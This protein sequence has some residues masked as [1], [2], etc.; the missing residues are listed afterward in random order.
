MKNNVLV[1]MSGGVDSAVCA[2]LLQS[3][4]MTVEGITMKLWSDTER[5]SD[6]EN[7]I[8]DQNCIDARSVADCLGIPHRFVTLG[9]TFRRTVIDPF[10][11]SYARG[12]TPNPCVECNRCVKFGY[13]MQLAHEQG[14]DYL[15]T[16]HY[17][18]IE[19]T[20]QGDYVLKKAKDPL[21]DQSYF[22]WSIKKKYLPSLL[23]PLG[24]YTKEEI[25]G[26][27]AEK[28]IPVAHRSDSQD[29]CFIPDGDYVSFI[30]KHSDLTFPAG[31]FIS[32]DG[33]ILGRHGGVIRYTI[34]QRK[35]LGISLGHP[36]FVGKI[37]PRDHTVTL[38]TDEELYTTQLTA[39]RVNWLQ[40]RD[41]SK[42]L[43]LEAKIRYRHTP[44][45]ATV[46]PI[47]KT[48]VSVEFDLPQRAV[49]P[50]QSIVFYDGDVVV[51]GGII[52]P[53]E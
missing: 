16:G 9:E 6:N 35:G 44:A 45:M 26:I 43:R 25:R 39:S 47:E 23:F 46:T 7:T 41:F 22:L 38:C 28:Q 32:P 49:S 31:D 34:G 1:A 27:A 52:D 13:L 11:Q 40:N 30:A 14:F 15:A 42:H 17:A 8:P 5:L 4:G 48:R 24:A 21:K 18:R 19:K 10:I 12:M 51:G 53:T 50:G 33:K 36:A 20:I 37:S 29:I 2:Y 3:R